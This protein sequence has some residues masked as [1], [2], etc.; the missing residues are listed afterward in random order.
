MKREKIVFAIGLILL[1]IGIS[2]NIMEDNKATYIE[3]IKFQ[4]IDDNHKYYCEIAES[5]GASEEY[6]IESNCK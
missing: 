2:L 6:L 3:P 5:R 4:Y 1:A